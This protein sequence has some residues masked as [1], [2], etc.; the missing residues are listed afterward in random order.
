[1]KTSKPILTLL[2]PAVLIWIAGFPAPAPG[3]TLVPMASVWKYHD[4]GSNLLTAWIQ[5]GYDDSQWLS[6][7]AQLGYGEGDEATLAGYGPDPGDKFIT[8]YFR[9]SFRVTNAASCSNLVLRLLCDDGAVGYLN[10]LELVRAFMPAGPAG[11]RTLASIST[12]DGSVFVTPVLS[13][14]MLVDGTNVLAVEVH[15]S[16]SRSTDASFDLELAFGEPPAMAGFLEVAS[17]AVFTA[18]ANLSLT[19]KAVMPAGVMSVKF[20][21]NGAVVE[22]R[23]MLSRLYAPF[24][25]QFAVASNYTLAVSAHDKN[26]LASTTAVQVA[27]EPPPPHSAVLVATGAVWRFL[28]DG[29]DPGAAWRAAGYDDAAWGSGPAALGYSKPGLATTVRA[30][31]PGGSPVTTTYFRHAWLAPDPARFHKLAV[32]VLGDDG[33]RVFL[34]GTEIFRNNLP[35]EPVGPATPALESTDPSAFVSGASVDASLLVAGTNV[36]AVEVHQAAAGTADLVF[37]LELAAFS[38][39][40]LSIQPLAPGQVQLA[41]PFPSAGRRLMSTPG[42][43]PADWTAVTNSPAQSGQDFQLTL[44][45]TGASRFFRLFKTN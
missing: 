26:G 30:T 12:P 14:G 23:S 22:E 19:A 37:N 9:H 13:P 27:V 8:T 21:V 6:G 31:R 5:P 29:S 2:V 33:A 34:N 1:M 15:Q 20:H 11:Y 28:D 44:P 17:N 35:S 40:P 24:N 3:G 10:G 43:V 42:L 39:A 7:R 45:C 4:Q 32:R 18:P 38:D 41:W 16:S 25:R 36:L